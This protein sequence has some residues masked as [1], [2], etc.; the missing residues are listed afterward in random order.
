MM[1][2]SATANDGVA[3]CYTR[4]IGAAARQDTSAEDILARILASWSFGHGA[5]PQWLG[6]GE[7]EFSKMLRNHFPSIKPQELVGFE[8]SPMCEN[9]EEMDDLRRLIINNRSNR[10]KSEQWLAEILVFGCLGSDHLW[11]DLGLW[12]RDDLSKLMADHFTPL[13]ELNTKNMK[14][15]KFLYKRLCE[16]EG[17]YTCR[18]PSCEACADY[19]NCFGA[20]D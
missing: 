1:F 4:L 14:W 6:L 16:T 11:Q 20:E 18:A 3:Q 8:H 15:K 19:S 5:L 12:S 2:Q 7:L 9:D 13:A 17:I 10:S